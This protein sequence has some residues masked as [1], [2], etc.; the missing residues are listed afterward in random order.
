MSNRDRVLQFLQSICP[1]DA[2]NAD[3]VSRTGI[4]PHAQV[5]QITRNLYQLGLISGSQ[6][7]GEWRFW[8][9]AIV[10]P[11]AQSSSNPIEPALPNS[12]IANPARIFEGRACRLMSQ[13]FGLPLAPA[14]VTG[15]PKAFDLVSPEKT[16]VGDA[17]FYTLVNDFSLPPAKFS[18]ITEY[19]WLL[20]KTHAERKFL[21]FGNERRVPEEWLRRFGKLAHEIEFYFIGAPDVVERLS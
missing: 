2:T 18:V 10:K 7:D 3:I 6:G 8:A 5:F 14:K 4:R 11:A 16:I 17:K 21:V 12:N 13:Y 19:V 1:R 20:E 9:K 15:V